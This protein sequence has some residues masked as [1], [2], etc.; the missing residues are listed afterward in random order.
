M[1]VVEMVG[2]AWLFKSNNKYYV[3]HD[4]ND[5]I[6]DLSKDA[7]P[8]DELIAEPIVLLCNK[9]YITNYSCSGHPFNSCTYEVYEGNQIDAIHVASHIAAIPF[10]NT[11]AVAVC[12]LCPRISAE[13]YISFIKDYVFP[14]LPEGWNYSKHAIRTK[15]SADSVIEYYKKL[16]LSIEKLLAWINY[17]PI[18]N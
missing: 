17:L 16:I 13:S 12:D 18:V 9:G 4:F 2:T 8:I 6:C 1:S 14:S 3:T 5:D 15:I 11:N 7:V 10:G